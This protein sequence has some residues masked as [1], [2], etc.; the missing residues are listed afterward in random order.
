MAALGA[1]IRGDLPPAGNPIALRREGVLPAFAG[2]RPVWLNCGTAALALAL[3]LARLRRPELA[4]PEVVLP[5]YACPDLVAAALFAGVKPVLADIGRDDPGYDLAA[6]AAVLGSNTIAV[7]AVNFL[8]IRERLDAIRTLLTERTDALLIED[9]AQ[10]FPEPLMQPPLA[11]DLVCISFGRGKPVSLLGGG[12]LLVSDALAPLLT[13]PRD[14]PGQSGYQLAVKTL[15][16]NQ[17]LRPQFYQLLSRNPWLGLGQTRFKP[18][19]A[20]HA[21]DPVR[22]A[23]LPANI[24]KHVEDAGDVQRQL[25]ALLARCDGVRDLAA[26]AGERCG[27]LLRYPVL[28]EN[29]VAR[30]RL[31]QR[32]RQAGLG[33]TA[34]YQRALP[35]IEGV[36]GRL[37]ASPALP[38]AEAFAGRLLT[39][40]V[41]AG[42][43][44]RHL[45]RLI[46][47]LRSEV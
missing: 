3:Q 40:P 21:M 7:V 13:A 8:G 37:A 44:R 11:G 42:V 14:M 23:L 20:I 24:R 35:F 16:Y 6:L 17:L 43:H 27:R 31:W 2:Y 18:L 15:A 9:D 26:A 29:E 10:W 30:D 28:C 33:A 12:A 46:T 25:C 22:L 47:V 5:G 4:Q 45:R 39:L 41:H 1:L 36:A 32:L 38:G 34:M 19:A